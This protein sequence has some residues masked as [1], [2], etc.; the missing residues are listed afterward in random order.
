MCILTY[1]YMLM[2]AYFLVVMHALSMH[3]CTMNRFMAFAIV[4][5]YL[6]SDKRIYVD[7]SVLSHTRAHGT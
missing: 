6:L 3:M 4:C 7:T 2:K 5:T 1:V